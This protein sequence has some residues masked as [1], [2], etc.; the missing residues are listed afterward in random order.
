MFV[1]PIII[2]CLSIFPLTMIVTF[3]F[4]KVISLKSQFF[5]KIYLFFFKFFF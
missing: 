2:F 3:I 5:H 4:W 1:S